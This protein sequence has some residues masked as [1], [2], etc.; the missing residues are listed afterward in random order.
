VSKRDFAADLR[1]II[2]TLER[3]RADLAEE[4]SNRRDE[5]AGE[6]VRKVEDLQ[7]RAAELLKASQPKP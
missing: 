6:L 4:I 3:Q 7:R 2:A 5:E 1:G